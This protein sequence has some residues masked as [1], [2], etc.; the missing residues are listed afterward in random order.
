MIKQ[1][2][3]VALLLLNLMSN[4][5]ENTALEMVRLEF[6]EIKNEADI[7]KLLAFEAKNAKEDELQLIKAYQAA[8]TCMMANYVSSAVS[9]LKYFKAGKKDLE[10]LILKGKEVENVYLRLLLQLNVPRL[11]NYRKN[12]EEDMAYL[13]SSLAKAPIDVS[14]KKTMIENLVSVAKKQE[15]KEVLLQIKLVEEG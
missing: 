6:Q 3:I 2:F 11:L 13:E 7:E 8:G 1:I 9:K 10:E 15:V 12:I 14:Y 4:A 5:Q